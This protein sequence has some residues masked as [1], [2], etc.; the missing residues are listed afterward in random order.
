MNCVTPNVHFFS[1]STVQS[2]LLP[3]AVR[4][5]PNTNNLPVTS[6]C[7]TR[8]YSGFWNRRQSVFAR[9]IIQQ[10]FLKSSNALSDINISPEEVEK[11]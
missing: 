5:S 10:R 1:N 4:V 2:Y 7:F 3:L 6:T 11:N 8:R 9:P